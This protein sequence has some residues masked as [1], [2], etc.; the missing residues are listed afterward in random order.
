[1]L[2]RLGPHQ[3]LL[4][5]PDQVQISRVEVLQ[6]DSSPFPGTLYLCEEAELLGAWLTRFRKDSLS[7]HLAFILPGELRFVYPFVLRADLVVLQQSHSRL[8][9]GLSAQILQWLHE[10]STPA[11]I[12]IDH[13]RSE[14]VGELVRG[15]YSSQTSLLARARAAGLELESKRQVLLIEPEHP[16]AAFQVQ[17]AR[18]EAWLRERQVELLQAVRRLLLAISPHHLVSLHGPG[19]IILLDERSP[20]DVGTLS[21]QIHQ[22]L[23]AQSELPHQM[24]A[25]GNPVLQLSALTLSMQQAQAALE[26]ARLYRLSAPSPS[27]ENLRMILFLHRLQANPELSPLL[28]E[29]LKPLEQV[30][31]GYRKALLE[32]LAAYIENSRSVQSAARSLGVHPNTLK[33]RIRRLEELLDLRQVPLDRL[34]L[35]YLAARILLLRTALS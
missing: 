6:T 15:N 12:D 5:Q 29:A 24:V 26:V 13:L 8:S 18:G 27:F 10:E 23:R 20:V 31:T 30:E 14:L 11:R 22:L 35:Y 28:E 16:E 32:S 19:L 9:L 2:A 21:Q 34:L 17:I 7:R 4:G 33:Y 3:T 1:M 25:A